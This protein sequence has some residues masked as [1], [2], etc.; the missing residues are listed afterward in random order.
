M[1]RAVPVR[2]TGPRREL[3]VSVLPRTALPGSGAGSPLVRTVWA[4]R[5]R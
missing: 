3:A 4:L 1:M 2:R 5:A